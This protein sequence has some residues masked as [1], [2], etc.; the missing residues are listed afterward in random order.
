MDDGNANPEQARTDAL[1]HRRW[2]AEHGHAVWCPDWCQEDHGPVQV[3]D[4]HDLGVSH[5][6]EPLT[7][8][9]VTGVYSLW[10]PSGLGQREEYI[11]LRADRA[12]GFDGDYLVIPLDA[13]C[14]ACP[15]RRAVGPLGRG[16]GGPA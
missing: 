14:A 7:I 13:C 6:H 5:T 4:P 12:A 3:I 2:L 1:A 10:E 11:T 16:R 8:G 15:A 9:A